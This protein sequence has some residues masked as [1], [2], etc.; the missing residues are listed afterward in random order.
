MK[1]LEQR[2]YGGCQAYDTALEQPEAQ[3]TAALVGALLRNVY[4]GDEA[5]RPWA[6]LLARYLQR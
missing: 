1:Q 5:E 6:V 2:F 3:R 4:D